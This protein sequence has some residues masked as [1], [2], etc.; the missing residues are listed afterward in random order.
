M[1]D[2]IIIVIKS[3]TRLLLPVVKNKQ[4]LIQCH[5][6]ILS[7]FF[8]PSFPANVTNLISLLCNEKEKKIPKMNKPDK[9]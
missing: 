4:H 5:S 8:L 6:L 7:L 2:S 1:F 3:K 9:I